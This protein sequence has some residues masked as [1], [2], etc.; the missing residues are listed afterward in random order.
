MFPSLSTHIPMLPEIRSFLSNCHPATHPTATAVLSAAVLLYIIVN[1]VLY[2]LSA[3]IRE[4]P[5]PK[6][7]NWLTGSHARDVWEL[8]S[9][10]NQLEWTRQYGHVF[11]YYG[12]F[13]VRV[14]LDHRHTTSR[15]IPLLPDDQ[16][17]HY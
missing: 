8:D 4:L 15:V 2:R 10:D 1:S 7:V 3:P 14:N 6:S 12:W 9:L 5:G 11:K 13:N 17:L 16:G